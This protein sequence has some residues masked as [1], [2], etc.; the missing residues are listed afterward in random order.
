MYVCMYINILRIIYFYIDIF[1]N[2][3]SVKEFRKYYF[4]SVLSIII[5]H[6][7][8]YLLYCNISNKCLKS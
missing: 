8:C 5:T 2:V 7:Y 4:T 3:L 1:R 6:G